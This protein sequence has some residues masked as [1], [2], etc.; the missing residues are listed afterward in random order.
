[1]GQYCSWV[2][3][4]VDSPAPYKTQHSRF[5]VTPPPCPGRYQSS[6]LGSGGVTHQEEHLVR[7]VSSDWCLP[8]CQRCVS[9]GAPSPAPSLA[10]DLSPCLLSQDLFVVVAVPRA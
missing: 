4:S 3:S 10:A 8:D 6:S 7:S 5:R 1:M 9:P 2:N